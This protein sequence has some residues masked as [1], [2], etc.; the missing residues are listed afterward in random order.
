MLKLLNHL[1]THGF[2]TTRSDVART[3]AE[4]VAMCS[5]RG[6]ITTQLPNGSF[7]NRWRLTV[8]GL[9]RIMH[10]HYYQEG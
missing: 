1:N 8:A 5:L 4:V 10:P 9:D 7:G 3:N 2:V 6:L